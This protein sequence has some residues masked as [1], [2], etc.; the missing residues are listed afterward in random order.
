MGKFLSNI[1]TRILIIIV[2]GCV[3][4]MLRKPHHNS[5][6]IVC[7]PRFIR[8]ITGFAGCFFY[9]YLLAMSHFSSAID[10][11]AIADFICLL[12]FVVL[13][14]GTFL[15]FVASLNWKLVY[16]DEGF[17]FRSVFRHTSFFTYSQI[18]RIKFSK[19][20]YNLKIKTH[21]I[22]ISD[23]FENSDDFLQ[24]LKKYRK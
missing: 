14:L 13:W 6:C 3:G 4:V 5:R 19:S 1:L 22:Y 2:C 24:Y 11:T 8:Y 23:F 20:G 15:Y 16:S 17:L 21:T 7:C 18:D 12:F 9:P 10:L